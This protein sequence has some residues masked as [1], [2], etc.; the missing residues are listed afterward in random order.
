VNSAGTTVSSTSTVVSYTAVLSVANADLLLKPGMTATA[1]IVT[2]Q[3]KNVLLVPNAALRFKPWSADGGQGGQGASGRNG[4]GI[5]SVLIPPRG[6]RGGQGGQGR[7]GRQGG[8]GA[9]APTVPGSRGRV[10]VV[11]ED[12]KP[13]PIR[14]TLGE[15][16]G[17]V[18]EVTGPD[19][20]PGLKV[21]TGRLSAAQAQ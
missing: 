11:G 21:I 10:F 7:Q 13:R 4:G 6:R 2:A 16:N 18:T 12:G 9:E 5:A 3:K 1:D 8:Q 17:S 20:Q 14:V 15:T 19:I